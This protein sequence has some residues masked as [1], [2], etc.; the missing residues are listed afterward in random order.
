MLA[1]FLLVAVTYW[2]IRELG[3]ATQAGFGIAQRI[4][5]ALFV[6]VLAVAFAAAPVAG[7]NFGAGRPERVKETFRAAALMSAAIM[8]LDTLLCQWQADGLVKLFS[9]DPTAVAVGDGYLRILS[10][11]FVA[12]GFVFT[13]SSLF[14]AL[15]NAWPALISSGTRTGLFLVVAIWFGLQGHFELRHLWYASVVTVTLQAVF[16]LLLLQQQFRRR[17][18]R[19]VAAS[20]L[21]AP[22]NAGGVLTPPPQ[23]L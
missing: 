20:A 4:M 11:N 19:P 6:P 18:A 2:A 5:Q 8:V 12:T 15:G 9:S 17:L 13:C 10:W 14:Q 23:D 16:S 22:V 21:E 7:Q 1:I 3:P